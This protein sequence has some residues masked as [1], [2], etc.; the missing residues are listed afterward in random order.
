MIPMITRALLIPLLLSLAGCGYHLGEI[1]PTPMRRVT[2]IAVPT[3]KNKTLLP[4]LEAQTADAVAKQFQ[5]DGTY[6]IESPDRADAIIEGTIISVERQ[7][8]RIFASNVL[9]TSEFEL[10]LRVKYRV[11]DRVTGA[12]LMEGTAVGV[13]PFFT[14]ADLVNSDLVTNQNMNYPIAAQRMA[15]NLVSKVAEGW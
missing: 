5:Q 12:V 8:M 1:K 2:T 10:T 14:E 7:P 6:R 3:F 11:I 9:Q 15:Q 4:R 13:T